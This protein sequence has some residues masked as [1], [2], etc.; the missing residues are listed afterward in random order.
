MTT[1]E[2][3]ARTVEEAVS[4]ALSQLGIT[5][6]AAEIE[7]LEEP[8]K[9]LFGLFGGKLA[10]VRVS[11]KAQPEEVARAFL[12]QLCEHMNAR[13]VVCAIT[14]ETV[15]AVSLDVEGG[16][17]GLLIGKRGQTLDAIQQLTN[18][19]YVRAGGGHKRIL[20]DVNSYRAK[21]IESL[22]GLAVRL[23]DKAKTTG[24]RVILEPMGA[25]ERRVIHMAL[26]EDGEVVTYSEGED[27]YRKV[28]IALK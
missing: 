19:V 23:A 13:G 16:C 24:R 22:Q 12:E 21:R 11:E 1:V 3:T 26:Q 8:N 15:D 2:K 14:N 9:G 7:I 17:S 28:I 4:I 25:F 18:M 6:D 27:P 10:R 20:V 5:I